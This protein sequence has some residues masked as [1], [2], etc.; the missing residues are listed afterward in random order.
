MIKGIAEIDVSSKRVFLRADL[1]VPLK[2]GVVRDSTRIDRTVPTIKALLE[3]GAKV[4]LA[5][6]LG[7]PDG[8]RKPEMSMELLKTAIEKSLG[9]TIAFVDDCI[10]EKVENAVAELADGEV[11]LLE[12]LRFYPEEEKGDAQF[13]QKLASLADVYINDAFSCAHR[14][15]AST[16]VMA[17]FVAV[18]A[19]GLLM[20]EELSA[21]DK[22]LGNP[23][24]PVCAIVAGAK[25]STKLDLLNN[26][27][28][29]V[30]K[31]VIGGAMANTF[32]FAKGGKVGKSLYEPDLAETAKNIMAKAEKINCEIIL[33]EDA[34][35]GDTLAEGQE[36]ILTDLSDV[37]ED[38]M[39]LDIGPKSTSYII[40][41]LSSCKTF[42]WNGPVGAFEYP[43]FDAAT[44][45]IAQ[46][47]S[48]LTASGK[49]LSVAGGGDTVSALKNAGVKE[50][51]SYISTAGGAFLEWME[52]K[53]LPGVAALEE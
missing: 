52:G 46:A 38:K 40:E 3:K 29:K 37:P 50:G 28:E 18:K 48:S 32:I 10:G 14:A 23:E 6:H 19:A 42:I 30:D 1:N 53:T 4:I 44:N 24:R 26:L 49:L 17:K 31:L 21:L 13:A 27:I 22:A 41:V 39:I 7:R 36:K 45:A 16:A 33:P 20:A 8:E 25:V 15:H 47:A 35:L 2:D 43:P 34:S 11:L 5:S 51:F 9:Q 12:N